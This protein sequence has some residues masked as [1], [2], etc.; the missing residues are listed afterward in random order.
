LDKFL[1]VKHLKRW[2]LLSLLRSDVFARGVPWARLIL[3]V[4]R[5]PNDLNLQSSSRVSVALVYV[6]VLCSALGC[7]RPSLWLVMPIVA[8]MLL[9]LNRD[10]YLF[11][12]AK[13]GWAVALGAVLMH[14]LYYFYGGLSFGLGLVWH[15]SEQ[16]TE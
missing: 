13:R 6:G 1:Q 9:G 15:Y 14:W 3:R 2:T 16:I 12:M 5:M 7:L 11:F 10:V 8:L 4:G